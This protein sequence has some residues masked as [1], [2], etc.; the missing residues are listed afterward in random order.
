MSI[1]FPMQNGTTFYLLNLAH[2]SWTMGLNFGGMVL[3]QAN[4]IKAKEMTLSS[5]DPHQNCLSSLICLGRWEIQG[6]ASIW[7][8]LFINGKPSQMVMMFGKFVLN[9]DLF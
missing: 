4:L 1:I 6:R 3:S 2:H 8:Y 9:D 7:W 5:L